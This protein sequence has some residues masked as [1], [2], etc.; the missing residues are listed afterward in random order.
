M[1]KT[2]VKIAMAAVQKMSAELD[3]LP[4]DG[5]LPSWWVGK[6]AI[7]VDKLDGM[8]DYLDTQVEEVQEETLPGK[9]KDTWMK[10]GVEMCPE[11][12]CGQPVT[13]CKCSTD[14]ETCNCAERKEMMK[15]EAYNEP[16]GQAKSMMSPLHKARI[17]K[18]KADRDRDGKLKPG[19]VKVKKE[20]VEVEEAKKV[21]SMQIHKVL[22]PTKN[23]REGIAALKKAFRVN[24]RE[25][26]MMLKKV[27]NEET[28]DEI[29]RSMTPMSKRFGKAVD[30]KKFD[31]YKKHVKQH[32]VDEPTVRFI[33]DNPNHNQSKRAM[34]DKH[35]A[36]AVKLYKD[37]HK[38]SVDEVLDTP[39]RVMNYKQRAKYSRDRASN[40]QAAHMMRGTD[41]S[42]DKDTER[43]RE[44]GL[45]SLNRNVAG[46][47]R[48]AMMKNE[49]FAN[50][51]QQ[52]AVMAKLKASGKYKKEEVQEAK[53]PDET[54]NI[55]QSLKKAVDMRGQKEVVFKDGSKA[56]I[57]VQDA[58]KA[59]KML[60]NTRMAKAKQDLT[61]RM[62][63]SHQDFKDTLAGKKPKVDPFA[64]R[65]R[66]NEEVISEDGSG[67]T[68]SSEKSKLKP[69]GHR[70]HLINPKG[71]TA[72]LGGTTYKTAKHAEGEA[73]AYHKAYFNT[74]GMKTNDRGA[75][76]AVR[77]YKQKNKQH[78][79]EDNNPKIVRHLELAKKARAEGD[80]DK[81]N[82]H[83]QLARQMQM[84]GTFISKFKLEIKEK[85]RMSE[86][87]GAPKGYHFTRSGQLKKG[88]AG[89]DGDG[90]KMLRS[91]P[92][93]KQRKKIP[94][95]PENDK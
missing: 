30:P 11:E 23:S 5:D 48:N 56:K 81:A 79:M 50:A 85:K 38:E 36:Q 47:I 55:R 53:K 6:V 74:P 93:D 63:K 46:K 40:S 88:D 16:Q 20:E 76:R 69:G 89:Q 22:A 2:K 45:K 18:E 65:V 91:D 92:L 34:Q 70:S 66:T 35:V 21:S 67:Y 27:M 49:K 10:D 78:V 72:Y 73:A 32:K 83:T 17:D 95:L 60:D 1:A 42:K 24:D 84:E 12:C 90:G 8:A 75:E 39:D 77:H 68:P 62:M 80:Y 13:E 59:M 14:C 54:V 25:A 28:I 4:D 82:Y 52:A 33:D 31:V 71:K 64:L 7:A 26:Q 86:T 29:S 41:P 15:A 9:G 43:K 87:K 94:P 44:K 61:I 51:A 3:K 19:V 58:E 57:S 37:A